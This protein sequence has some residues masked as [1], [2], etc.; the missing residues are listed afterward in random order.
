MPA[1]KQP[2]QRQDRNDPER[3]RRHALNALISLIGEQVINAL[4]KPGDFLQVQVRPLW[5]NYYR[6]NV[7]IGKEAGSAHVADSYFLTAD[8]DGNIITSTP[9]ITK[10]Y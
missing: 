10:K 3:D 6:A 4:G 1:T 5:E 8:A 7:F 9:K 2:E